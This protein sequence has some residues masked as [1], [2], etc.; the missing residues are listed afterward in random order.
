M[1]DWIKVRDKVWRKPFARDEKRGIQ[2]DLMRIEPDFNDT[3][4][5]HSDWEWVYILEGSLVD[6]KGIHKKGDFL[7]NDKDARH[8]PKSKEGC[9]M[10]IVWS[11]G[12]RQ[13]P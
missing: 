9:K 3:P 6:D 8:Q 11:G 10:I 1:D 4:H 5:W 13:K 12:V 2:M 7:L